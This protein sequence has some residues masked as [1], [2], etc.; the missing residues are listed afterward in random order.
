MSRIGKNPV[1]IPAGVS[2][3]VDSIV[4]TVYFNFVYL[5]LSYLVFTFVLF[6]FFFFVS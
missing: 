4:L 5:F 3:Q 2:V 6:F 1:A